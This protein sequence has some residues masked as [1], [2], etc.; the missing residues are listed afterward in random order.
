[1]KQR[2][3]AI[4]DLL[5]AMCI[6]AVAGTSYKLFQAAGITLIVYFIVTRF[7]KML[8]VIAIYKKQKLKHEPIK[9]WYEFFHIFL[10]AAFSVLTPVFF[11][12]SLQYTTLSNTYFLAYTMPAWVLVFSVIFLKEHFSAKKAIALCLTL[13]GIYI[14]ARPEGITSINP[15][16]IFAILS[17]LSF[18]GDVITARELKNYSYQ[19]VSLYSNI[20]QFM[21]FIPAVIAIGIPPQDNPLALVALSVLGIMLGVA[22]YAYYFALEK[23]EASLAAIITL[24][25][26]LAASV[27]AFFLLGESPAPTDYAGYVLILYSAIILVLRT[28]NIKNFERLLHIKMKH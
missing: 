13:L 11:F 27:L 16:V 9:N 3:A 19:T 5:F 21:L 23:I 7:F 10:N 18:T 28:P 26:L 15:G 12:I 4:A 24:L 22:S 6:W 17:A 14:I 20:L 2:S 1:M 8:S 25:E